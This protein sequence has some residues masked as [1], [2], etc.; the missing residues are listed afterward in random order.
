MFM[1]I[2]FSRLGKFTSTIMLKMFAGPLSWELVEK[3]LMA[4]SISLGIIGLFRSFT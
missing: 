4:A 3:L 2:S 1:G